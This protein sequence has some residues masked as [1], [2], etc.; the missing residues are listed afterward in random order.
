MLYPQSNEYRQA[1]S[2]NGLWNFRADPEDRGVARRWH[3]GLPQGSR[4]MPVPASFNDLTQD[5]ALRD[6]VGP[7]WYEREVFVPETHADRRVVVR[8]G[9]AAHHATVWWNGEL[10]AEHKGGFLPFEADVTGRVRLRGPNTLVVRV[11]NRINWTTLPPGVIVQQGDF[12][13]SGK[14][15][16][17]EYFADFFNYSG[18]HR[19]V[20]L[21]VTARVHI[22]ALRVTPWRKG[23]QAGFDYRVAVAGGRAPVNVRLRDAEGAL[24]AQGEG[25]AGS[26]KVARPKLWAPGHPYLYT[27]EAELGGA[28]PDLYRLST[29]LRTVRVQG[30]RLLLNDQPVYL[31]GFG[32]H[33]DSD[34][35]GKGH[36]DA[37]MIKDFALL[38]WIGANSFRTSHYPYAEEIL[39]HADREGILVI[40]E[41]PAVG[42]DF[43]PKYAPAFQPGQIDERTREHHLQTLREMMARD[44]NHPSIV[45]WSLANE[46]ATYEKRSRAYFKP[47][48]REARKRD[49]SRPRMIVMS[50]TP[51]NDTVGDLFDVLGVNRYYGWYHDVAELD[52]VGP[53]LEAELRAWHA[54]YRKPIVMTEFGA[55]TLAGFHQDPPVMFSEE[56]QRDLLREN[57]RV[58]DRLPFVV[59]EHVWN[60]ADFATKQGL[61]RVGGN[62]KGVFTR[63]RQPKLAAHELRARW[64]G[65]S[66]LGRPLDRSTEI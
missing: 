23:K 41:L 42:M 6:L 15:A 26:L 63:Q 64:S 58:L 25:S 34:L 48:V 60:F 5:P 21:T 44:A 16:R 24:V 62:R 13:T 8:V 56:F 65:C 7:V 45:L 57:Q 17:Q 19:A 46:A 4:Q 39:D 43:M 61:K 31:R 59:G 30:S 22:A 49:P 38:K 54:R 51:H 1:I 47:I 33:E 27:L 20:T 55:D 50:A 35:L 9:A 14:K 66:P 12:P 40:G 52:T 53:N 11:D 3:R 28:S 29:G 32:K 18:I 36:S 2:L 10:V 37:V